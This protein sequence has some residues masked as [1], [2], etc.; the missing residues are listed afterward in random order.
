MSKKMNLIEISRESGIPYPTILQMY[1]G[2]TKK[3]N[4]KTINAFSLF[5]GI[6][7]EFIVYQLLM[8]R[9]KMFYCSE[10]SLWHLALNNW[11][12]NRTVKVKE[13]IG[14]KTFDGSYWDTNN[15]RHYTLIDSWKFLKQRYWEECIS[16]PFSIENEKKYKS[17][18]KNDWLYNKSILLYGINKICELGK[19]NDIYAYDIVFSEDDDIDNNNHLFEVSSNNLKFNVSFHKYSVPAEL[20]YENLILFP[21]LEREV[22]NNNDEG[23]IENQSFQEEDVNED[24]V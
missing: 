7:E 15:G 23:L 6:P 16:Y 10:E 5:E 19:K 1:V 2:K 21:D 13:D 24:A 12:Y 14:D 9:D 11:R 20:K 18:I 17:N 22:G 4:T 8:D 3:L